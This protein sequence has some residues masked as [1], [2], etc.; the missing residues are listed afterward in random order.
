[1]TTIMEE[2][3]EERDTTPHP[4]H[5]QLLCHLL[6]LST[7]DMVERRGDPT[8]VVLVCLLLMT[9]ITAMVVRREERRDTTPHLHHRLDITTPILD[10][11]EDTMVRRQATPRTTLV[12]HISMTMKVVTRITHT[13]VLPFLFLA[14]DM[15]VKGVKKSTI[16]LLLNI[17]SPK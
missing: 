11:E 10:M 6:H 1:M 5:P 9:M 13:T 15:L 2:R 17:T 7:V 14:R 3:R 16:Y 8:T 4:H 12:D